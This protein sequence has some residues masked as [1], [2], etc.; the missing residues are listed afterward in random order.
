MKTKLNHRCGACAATVATVAVFS[1]KFSF[2][3]I[4]GEHLHRCRICKTPYHQPPNEGWLICFICVRLFQNKLY[5]EK[6]DANDGI[7][8]G[9][10]L[11]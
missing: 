4:I 3:P 7:N 9:G 11:T 10:I 5:S 6:G 2:P 8:S 1:E